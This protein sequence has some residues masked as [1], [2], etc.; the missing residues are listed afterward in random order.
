MSVRNFPEV[1]SRQILVGIILVGRSGVLSTVRS[2]H[3]AGIWISE[4]LA[5]ADSESQGAEFPGPQAMFW[6][7]S[8]PLPSHTAGVC[9]QL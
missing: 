7:K 2:V 6:K 1:L 5:Q 8:L 4:S 9:E 3:E